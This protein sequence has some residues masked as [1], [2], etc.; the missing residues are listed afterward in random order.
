MTERARVATTV[1]LSRGQISVDGERVENTA[2][3]LK[4]GYWA[5]PR[6]EDRL[7]AR[8]AE[9]VKVNALCRWLPAGLDLCSVESRR[10][11]ATRLRIAASSDTPYMAVKKLF[12]TV[13][14]VGFTRV[15][16]LVSDEKDRVRQLALRWRH[17]DEWENPRGCVAECKRWGPP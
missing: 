17:C 15:D 7:N 4:P 14:K 13:N 12:F 11:D 9:L 5:L 3:I 2:L 8:R 10:I 6:L 16:F 1:T